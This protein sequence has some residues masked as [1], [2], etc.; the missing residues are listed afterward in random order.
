[1][2]SDAFFMGLGKGTSLEVVK[3][4]KEDDNLMNILKYLKR[5]ENHIITQ[6]KVDS[7]KN[8]KKEENRSKIKKENYFS[9]KINNN[10]PNQWCKTHKTSSHKTK[11]CFLNN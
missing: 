10:K 3:N 5:I 6:S 9:N 8:N 1:M 2:I 7:S 11:D 4:T